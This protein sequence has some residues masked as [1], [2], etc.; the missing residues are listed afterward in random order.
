M[1]RIWILAVTVPLAVAGLAGPSWATQS[2]PKPSNEHVTITFN[3]ATP[4]SPGT[5]A[6]TGPIAG[7]G[8][9][10]SSKNHHVGRVRFDVVTLTFGTGTVTVRDIRARGERKL[11][12]STCTV[13]ETGKGAWLMTKGTGAYANAKGHGRFTSTATL[14]GTHDP[15]SSHGCNLKNPTGTTVFDATG[16][17]TV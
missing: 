17:V 9:A 8:T 11:D 10:T 12:S 4:Q 6:A 7:S 13:T 14:V 1:R 15:S 3:A 2:S 5:V 16:N